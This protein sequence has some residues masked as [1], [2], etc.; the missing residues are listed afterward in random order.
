MKQSYF[1]V[2]AL[3]GG[4]ELKFENG[5]GSPENFWTEAAGHIGRGEARIVS[6]RTDTGACDDVREYLQQANGYTTFVMVPLR[7]NAEQSTCTETIL[8]KAAK[9]AAT[10]KNESVVDCDSSFQLLATK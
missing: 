2:L 9:R 5:K 3:P 10:P 8:R 4:M 1:I 6:R 7:L